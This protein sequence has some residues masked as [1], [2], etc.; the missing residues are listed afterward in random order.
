[1]EHKL[2]PS[3]GEWRANRSARKL[4]ELTSQTD[5]PQCLY[6]LHMG[7]KRGMAIKRKREK[8]HSSPYQYCPVVLSYTYIILAHFIPNLRADW[9]KC[10]TDWKEGLRDGDRLAAS[11]LSHAAP[12]LSKAKVLTAALACSAA[13]AGYRWTACDSLTPPLQ[14]RPADSLALPAA[15]VQSYSMRPEPLGRPEQTGSQ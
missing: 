12:C 10:Q 13:P 1:M 3:S 4:Q 8:S 9:R 11:V 5:K 7:H 2:L 6:A 14:T 15:E